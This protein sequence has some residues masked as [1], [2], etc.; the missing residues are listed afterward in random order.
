MYAM[1]LNVRVFACAL[2]LAEAGSPGNGSRAIV[3]HRI[4]K[5]GSTLVTGFVESVAE[6]A[7]KATG[8]RWCAQTIFHAALDTRCLFPARAFLVAHLREP[9][10]RLR[11]VFWY[12]GPGQFHARDGAAV[13]GLWR[14]WLAC[15]DRAPAYFAEED[16]FSNPYVRAFSAA[17]DDGSSCAPSR[18]DDECEKCGPTKY[19]CRN[20]ALA[21]DRRR[22]RR[23]PLS[24]RLYP[25]TAPDAA[26]ARRVLERFDSVV[27]VERFD[28]S[29]KRRLLAALG[30]ADIL[31]P[32]RLPTYDG[33]PAHHI[34]GP[35]VDRSRVNRATAKLAEDILA[36]PADAMPR[37]L[38]D[39]WWDIELYC[40]AEART[41]GGASVD[42]EARL[43]ATYGGDAGARAR[44][45]DPGD[46][47]ASPATAALACCT[48]A[49]DKLRAG[50]GGCHRGKDWG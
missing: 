21:L 26:R 2:A 49:A 23:C 47:C 18:A 36:P 3:L 46:E 9:L 34:L 45:R 39:L 17:S 43:N 48:H 22:L 28:R 7:E 5:A 14:E 15:G 32:K 24:G 29:A 10:A 19:E 33:T 12:H 6:A 31:D 27:V 30:L 4:H 41:H 8:Q 25:M 50:P 38:D 16:Y 35:G 37:I 42:C 13:D 20:T 40:W 11:T 1:Y 44:L